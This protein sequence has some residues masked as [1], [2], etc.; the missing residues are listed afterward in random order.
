MI[1]TP[2]VEIVLEL[3]VPVVCEACLEMITGKN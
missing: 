2:M 3:A 1:V